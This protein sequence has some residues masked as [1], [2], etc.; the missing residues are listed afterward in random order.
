MVR[1]EG[2]PTTGD[3]GEPPSVNFGLEGD[4]NIRGRTGSMIWTAFSPNFILLWL[5]DLG[6]LS[7]EG[8]VAIAPFSLKC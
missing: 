5:T 4:H 8:F 1:C 6:R 2:D 7:P 3:D